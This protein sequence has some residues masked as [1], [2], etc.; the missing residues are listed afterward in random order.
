MLLF[1][2]CNSFPGGERVYNIIPAKWETVSY[3]A[4]RIGSGYSQKIKVDVLTAF[5]SI[6]GR[7]ESN[8]SFP[9]KHSS[10][11]LSN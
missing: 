4:E 11:I 5:P 2:V 8:I 1:S 7:M 9:I 6:A 3:N 10:T